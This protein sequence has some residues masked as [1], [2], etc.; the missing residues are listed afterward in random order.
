MTGPVVVAYGMG[1]D[2]T[3]LL[4]GLHQEGITPDLILFADTGDEKP[5]TYA[6]LPI[7][8]AWLARVGFPPVTVVKN[9]RPKSGDQSLSDS[10]LRLG[11]LPAL[12]YGK[13]QCSLVWKIAPQVAFLKTWPRA[14]EARAA[15]QPVTILIGYDNSPRDTARR[16]RAEGKAMAGGVNA[17]PLIA[18]GWDRA[19]CKRQIIR[20]GLPLPVKSAC[21]HCPAS[22]PSEI[23][24]L[25]DETPHL[26]A[27]AI[28]MEHGARAKGL[29]RIVGL[30]RRFSWESVA[31]QMSLLPAMGESEAA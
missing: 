19:A 23:I 14:M 16:Y 25:R 22:K 17:F 31:A 5:A 21:F 30:G 12:A 18:W 27:K 20:A 8:S 3:A 2:S 1:V 6:Y 29:R 11:T 15:G 26:Y 7:I 10:C 28:Q 9:P 24:A 4:I 13:H